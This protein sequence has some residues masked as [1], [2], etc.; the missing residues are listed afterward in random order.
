MTFAKQLI[1]GL[2]DPAE[3][4]SAPRVATSTRR[5]RGPRSSVRLGLKATVIISVAV[6]IVVA[7][8]GLI[9]VRAAH[10]DANQVKVLMN[11]RNHVSDMGRGVNDL[12]INVNRAM[13]GSQGI[14]T[15]TAADAGS[16]L[17]AGATSIGNELAA[18]QALSL[19]GTAR[20]PIAD[21]TT[22]LTAFVTQADRL[23]GLAFTNIAVASVALPAFADAA[24]QIDARRTAATAAL[25]VLIGQVERRSDREF[26]RAATV[27]GGLV[28]ATGLLLGLFVFAVGQSL[29]RGLRT[30]GDLAR[31]IAR[32]DLD[33]RAEITSDDELGALQHA[34]NDMAIALQGLVG[35]MEVTAERDG[36]GSQL[37]DALEMADNESEALRIVERAM[38][39]I[40]S[41]AP[42]EVLL[43]DSS[44]A[45][46][47]RV[48]SNPGVE[49][50][51]CPVESPFSCVAVRRGNPA[52]FD[53]SEALNA[54]PKLRG[55]KSGPVSAMC[56]PVTFMGRALG[57]LH[58][59]GPVG[60]PPVAKVV[61]QLTSLATQLGG[62]VGTIRS[63]ERS[64]LQ[65]TT[66]GLTG[67]RNRRTLETEIRGLLNDGVQIALVMA[68]LDHFKLLNDTYGHEAGDRA[69][70][71]FSQVVTAT[72]RDSDIVGRYGGE[73]F[74]IAFLGAPT[75]AAVEVLD[76]LREHL[77]LAGEESDYPTFTASFGV[78]DSAIGGSLEDLLR[79]ADAALYRAKD[80]GR[81]RVTVAD[82]R[83][84]DAAAR[85][86][87]PSVAAPA[88]S[89]R[90]L[91]T[92]GAFQRAASLDDPMAAAPQHR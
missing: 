14:G 46:L 16:N 4:S 83:D 5:R 41:T 56:V 47:E 3:R 57:V 60:A 26:G 15:L 27:L 64:Q 44:K 61:S 19:P 24:A 48:A 80:E 10:N 32:G 43:A 75:S 86:V 85:S 17:V 58:A 76:R 21:L 92:V 12:R 50:P 67:L 66:D 53:D 34:V 79:V 35:Q 90:T 18:L 89:R 84:V 1:A 45:H 70:R 88:Q 82:E 11:A 63:F 71:K 62:R 29:R 20:Q 2:V 39:S 77:A 51:C 9:S 6:A 28:V 55:R 65:A 68:D 54:C 23:S 38:T 74:V 69:L 7:G 36:F 30:L 13:L 52:V 42:M 22:L 72:V 49:A 73:E 81:N 91:A 40:S 87:E 31:S 8:T 25:D 37:S 78:V 33:A 59:T